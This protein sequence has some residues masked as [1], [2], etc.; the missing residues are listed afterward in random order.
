MDFILILLTLASVVVAGIL[1]YRVIERPLSTMA[2]RILQPGRMRPT[3]IRPA[4]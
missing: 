2:R 4:I 1:F 3:M